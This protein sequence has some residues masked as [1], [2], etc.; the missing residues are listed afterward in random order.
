M[1]SAARFTDLIPYVLR[2]V[3][4]VHQSHT[5]KAYC[6]LE[7]LYVSRPNLPSEVWDH[8]VALIRDDEPKVSGLITPELYELDEIVDSTSGRDFGPDWILG[9]GLMPLSYWAMRKKVSEQG[10]E[11][12]LRGYIAQALERPRYLGHEV[13]ILSAHW[14]F[15][16]DVVR[17]LTP[18]DQALHLQRFTEYITATY[19]SGGGD[20]IEHPELQEVPSEEELLSSALR[21]PGFF[22]Q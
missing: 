6:A 12:V 11:P 17:A 2:S 1:E 18:E 7:Q 4:Y 16:R 15:Y 10:F 5:C 22:G 8:C 3:A 19:A 14:Q 9:R 20:I 21:N 13:S